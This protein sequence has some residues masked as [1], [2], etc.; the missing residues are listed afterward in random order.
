MVHGLYQCS[1]YLTWESPTPQPPPVSCSVSVLWPV[2]CCSINSEVGGMKVCQVTCGY[3]CGEM[4]VVTAGDDAVTQPRR[5][6]EDVREWTN[7][8]TP[9]LLMETPHSTISSIC[10]IR[11]GEICWSGRGRCR[12]LCVTNKTAKFLAISL[13]TMGNTECSMFTRAVCVIYAECQMLVL[14]FWFP[15]SWHENHLEIT[16]N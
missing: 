11:T 3:G 16:K 13:S 2:P 4:I 6:W 15:A 7:T 8:P 5:H 12:F 9:L 10:P 14:F 1:G